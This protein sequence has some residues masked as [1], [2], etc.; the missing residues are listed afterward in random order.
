MG[1]PFRRQH[2]IGEDFVDYCCV[3]LGLVI[4]VDGPLH[5]LA[6]DSMRDTR[7]AKRG[8]EVMRF[9]VQE[10]DEN[11]TGV[12]DTIYGRVQMKLLERG[13]V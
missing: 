8:Y 4:E 11:L 12:V 13:E 5:D 9:S 10:M 2:V 1:A 3:T 7:L 6:R